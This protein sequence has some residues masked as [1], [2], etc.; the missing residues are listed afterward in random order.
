MT[1]HMQPRTDV[2]IWTESEPW[3][4]SR[5]SILIGPTAEALLHLYH[6]A[7][8]P[9][10]I[11]AAARQVLTREEFLGQLEDHRVDKYVAWDANGEPAGIIT[12]TRHLHA[13]PWISPEY[14]AARFP[15]QWARNAVYYLGFALARPTIQNPRFL[16]T[17]V[18]MA[19]ETLATERAVIAYDICFYNSSVL[20]FSERISELFTRYSD[21]RPEELDSQ[22]YY[23]VNFA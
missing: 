9:L 3:H 22:I 2:D 1:A 21:T 7:F 12:L 18:R 8:E 6:R 14:F 16:D 23:G 13:V 10:K 11:H 17:A 20:G 5:E 15:E 4:F 19:I